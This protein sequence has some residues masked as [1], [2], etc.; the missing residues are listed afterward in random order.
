MRLSEVPADW[1]A[2]ECSYCLD[3][4]GAPPDQGL[5][6]RRDAIAAHLL[7]CTGDRPPEARVAPWERP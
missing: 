7:L 2:W 6:E 5:A 3:V 1:E 4:L